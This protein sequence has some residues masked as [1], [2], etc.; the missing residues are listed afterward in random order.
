[1]KRILLS[2]RELWSMVTC[3][4]CHVLRDRMQ[5]Q[6]VGIG[7]KTHSSMPRRSLGV[8]DAHDMAELVGHAHAVVEPRQVLRLLQ[9]CRI[10]LP[11]ASTALQR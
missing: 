10:R 1:M 6:H 5:A 11:P 2:T 7:R 3:M 8:Q 9:Y 4:Q